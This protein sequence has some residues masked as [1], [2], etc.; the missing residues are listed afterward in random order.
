[1]LLQMSNFKSL[2]RRIFLFKDFSL[3][4][5]TASMTSPN[6]DLLIITDEGERQG[7][8]SELSKERSWKYFANFKLSSLVLRIVS[9]VRTC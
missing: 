2:L 5:S 4:L 3:S 6:E 9:R 1:M 8:G 7:I